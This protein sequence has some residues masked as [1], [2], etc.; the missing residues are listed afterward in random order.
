[1]S[2]F[3]DQYVRLLMEQGG[4]QAQSL[5]D[6]A[7]INAQSV[8]AQ[9]QARAQKAQIWGQVPG[10]VLN[11]GIG[12]YNQYLGQ[13]KEDRSAAL[14]NRAL[15]VKESEAQ[16]AAKRADDMARHQL[17]V[18]RQATVNAA[19]TAATQQVAQE[20][21]RMKAL[22]DII[23][24]ARLILRAPISSQAELDDIRQA[25]T[26]HAMLANHPEL[27][28]GIP[29]KFDPAAVET[30]RAQTTDGLSKA[31]PFV[32]MQQSAM[33]AFIAKNG[34][35]PQTPEELKTVVDS[36]TPT[37][38]PPRP[39]VLSN[40][41]GADG[42][43]VTK[44]VDPATGSTTGEFKEVPKPAS[45]QGAGAALPPAALGVSGEEAL[46][47]VDANTTRTIKLLA[48]YKIPL[49]TGAALRTPYWQNILGLTAAYDPTFDATQY[50]TRQGIRKGFTS[51]KEAANVRSLNTVI[52]HIDS[53]QKAADALKNS[54]F[55]AWNSVANF[56][57]SN[58]GDPRVVQF[59]VAATA[60]ENELASLF[61]GTGATDQEIH[62]WRT[63]L[64]PSS[65]AAQLSGAIT[66]AVELA[67]SRLDALKNQY[68]AGMGRPLNFSLLS[69]Q[70][71]KI[72][73]RYGIVTTPMG[74]SAKPPTDPK[75]SDTWA[76][77]AMGTLTW[78]QKTNG[79]Y[80]W[81]K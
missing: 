60:V 4:Q 29:T 48:D 5:R 25:L 56:A 22:P 8:V 43:P 17:E 42:K 67:G 7:A 14:Q 10:Q 21:E 26:K 66:K 45:L 15:S 36:I 28:S 77:P 51:G 12:A 68:E 13:Q 76:S 61:K 53:L 30:W 41:A 19:S 1:M 23:K 69:Q 62:Q 80:A 39:L 79:E 31:V 2:T 32:S 49:P 46:A 78:K 37:P 59:N 50:T 24:S 34:R 18:E 16:T 52:S 72:M 27:S 11:A 6:L 65:S 44:L 3:S 47:G 9:A 71:A 35:S 81:L 33:D 57:I 55:P 73:S 63:A 74:S 54:D 40:V 58:A 75:P 20:L 38:P 70:S 64:N